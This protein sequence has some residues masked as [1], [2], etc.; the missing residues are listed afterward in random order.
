MHFFKFK[1]SKELRVSMLFRVIDRKLRVVDISLVDLEI[2][3]NVHCT[4]KYRT[5][6]IS[7]NQM[8]Y[9]PWTLILMIE[10]HLKY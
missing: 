3:S 1:S 4:P 8:P 10:Y 7:V 5:F 2:H 9:L 6:Y